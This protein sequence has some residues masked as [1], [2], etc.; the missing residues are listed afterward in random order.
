[1]ED[2]VKCDRRCWGYKSTGA[3]I[4]FPNIPSTDEGHAEK[5]S[6]SQSRE[7]QRDLITNQRQKPI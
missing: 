2:V 5:D 4:P 6:Q 7:A 3:N 1:M